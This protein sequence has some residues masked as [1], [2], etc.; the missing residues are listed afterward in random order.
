M[1]PVEKHDSIKGMLKVIADY[2]IGESENA[3]LSF[4]GQNYD[5]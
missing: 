3:L 2:K 1:A 5:W 4:D